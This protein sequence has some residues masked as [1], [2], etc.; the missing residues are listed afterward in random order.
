MSGDKTFVDT[1]VLVYAYD[2]SAG[3]KRLKAQETI[4]GL[5]ETGLG[6]VSTQVL[7]EFFVTVTRK[8]PKAVDVAAARDI[9]NDLLT[10]EIV[11]VDG[12]MILKAID[13]Q[14]DHGYPFWD[15]LIIAA[16]DNAG[17]AVLLSEDL[18]AGQNLGGI[19]IRNPF[20]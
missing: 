17:C 1:N 19:E 3:L 9:V 16:A 18:A 20:G 6:V 11:M 13:L 8:I 15:S 4:A 10:W 5:W 7:Q 14:R 2:T 12:S